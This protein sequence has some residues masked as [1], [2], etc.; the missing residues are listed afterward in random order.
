VYVCVHEYMHGRLCVLP[1]VAYP[2]GYVLLPQEYDSNRGVAEA[3]RVLAAECSFC[4][5]AACSSL[6]KC[7]ARRPPPPPPLRARASDACRTAAPARRRPMAN[8]AL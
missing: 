5:G 3:A 1:S 4:D 8:T 7:A 2:G 6:W